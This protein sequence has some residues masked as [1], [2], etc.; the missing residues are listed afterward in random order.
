MA[1]AIELCVSWAEPGSPRL[2]LQSLF[3]RIR[4]SIVSQFDLGRY[5]NYVKQRYETASGSQGWTEFCYDVNN[6]V[7]I[8]AILEHI[9]TEDRRDLLMKIQLQA[10]RLCDEHFRTFLMPFCE[11]VASSVDAATSE[12]Q[13]CVRGLVTIYLARVVGEEPKR[14]TNWAR[15]DEVVTKTPGYI[16]CGCVEKVNTFLADP[17]MEHLKIRCKNLIRLRFEFNN[18]RHFHEHKSTAEDSTITKTTRCWEQQYAE[19]KER[20]ANALQAIRKLPNWML[21]ECLEE[22]VGGSSNFYVLKADGNSGHVSGL[23]PKI[24]AGSVVPKKRPRSEASS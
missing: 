11:V 6:V 7:P 9:T 2:Y 22:G 13:E 1:L 10:S 3:Q 24:Q 16:K 20:A 23:A 21:K 17:T 4:T 19:W 15:P 5:A 14:P 18:F 12:G 8:K